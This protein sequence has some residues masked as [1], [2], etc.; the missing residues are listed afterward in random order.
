MKNVPS[1]SLITCGHHSE[2]QT[3]C[4]LLADPRHV[5]QG[6]HNS[7]CALSGK[8]P[9]LDGVMILHAIPVPVV[10][11]TLNEMDVV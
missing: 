7:D 4:A 2:I 6:Q 1:L 5:L 9:H 3:Y 8:A 11:S 10:G